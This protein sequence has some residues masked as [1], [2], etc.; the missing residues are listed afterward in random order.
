M[1]EFGFPIFAFINSY[2]GNRVIHEFAGANCDRDML[3]A[4]LKFKFMLQPCVISQSAEC[5]NTR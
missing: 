5:D 3:N 4:F 1:I 2:V